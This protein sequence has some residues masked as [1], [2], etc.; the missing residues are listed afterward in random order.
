MF[1]EQ[2]CSLLP[3]CSFSFCGSHRMGRWSRELWHYLFNRVPGCLAKSVLLKRWG[4][5]RSPDSELLGH[6]HD[7]SLVPQS[8]RRD[9]FIALLSLSAYPSSHIPDY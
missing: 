2:L 4:K 9:Y 1:L 8:C 7:G 5:A 3:G 6:V